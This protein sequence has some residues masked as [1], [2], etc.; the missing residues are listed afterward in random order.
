MK[1]QRRVMEILDKGEDGDRAS[2]DEAARVPV[3][4]YRLAFSTG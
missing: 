2:R 4:H 1:L 3:G